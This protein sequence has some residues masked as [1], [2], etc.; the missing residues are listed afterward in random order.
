MLLHFL[1]SKSHVTKHSLLQCIIHKFSIVN[2]M[3]TRIFNFETALISFHFEILMKTKRQILKH[4]ENT[5]TH[6]KQTA[7]VKLN[8]MKSSI[9]KN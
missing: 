7:Q 6:I 9:K 1:K 5:L 3:H 2:R 4:F 8:N